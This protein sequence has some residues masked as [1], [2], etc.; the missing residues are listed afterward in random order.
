MKIA[1]PEFLQLRLMV[2]GAARH[3]GSLQLLLVDINYNS[4]CGTFTQLAFMVNVTLC[5]SI[6]FGASCIR[7]IAAFLPSANI[8]ISLRTAAIMILDSVVGGEDCSEL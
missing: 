8:G 5:V 4:E 7:F 6:L 1:A 2:R 3:R